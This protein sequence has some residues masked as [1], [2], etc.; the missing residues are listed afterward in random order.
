MNKKGFQ[1][2]G[3]FEMRKN[4][5]TFKKS[6]FFFFVKKSDEFSRTFVLLKKKRENIVGII[7]D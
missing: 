4:E 5:K 1:F 6:Q 3:I 7:R 2:F